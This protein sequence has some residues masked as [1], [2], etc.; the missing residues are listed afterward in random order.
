MDTTNISNL[1]EFE[2]LSKVMDDEVEAHVID[3]EITAYQMENL[4]INTQNFSI[5]SSPTTDSD[6]T[7]LAQER[8]AKYMSS[9]ANHQVGKEFNLNGTLYTVHAKRSNTG[10]GI[11]VRNEKRIISNP[12]M[13]NKSI[14]R[15]LSKNPNKYTITKV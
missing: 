2:E 4:G 6:N 7:S 14:R 11:W 3:D 13:K 10:M 15:K 12:N 9:R 1:I 8:M 5:G